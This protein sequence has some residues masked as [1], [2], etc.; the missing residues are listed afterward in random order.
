M[1][2]GEN[3]NY[4]RFTDDDISKL[5]SSQAEISSNVA[6]AAT[7]IEWI[8]KTYN[9]QCEKITILQKE[10]GDLK[11]TFWKYIGIGIGASTGISFTISVIAY[12]FH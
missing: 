7:N 12:F 1:V 4:H 10:V 5:I 9:A 3:P 11:T 2:L 8:V 6:V